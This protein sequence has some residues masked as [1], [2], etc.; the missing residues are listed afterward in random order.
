MS[1]EAVPVG[2]LVTN[3][4]RKVSLGMVTTFCHHN[5]AKVEASKALSALINVTHQ[6]YVWL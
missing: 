3:G 6:R 1:E 4:V 2:I 5:Q